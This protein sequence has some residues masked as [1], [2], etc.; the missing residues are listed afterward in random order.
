[1]IGA[2]S[3]Y[4]GLIPNINWVI[5]GGES[6]NK[7]GKYRYRECYIDWFYSIMHQCQEANVP[8]FIKQLGTY[9]AD[10]LKYKDRHG[11]DMDEWLD[12]LR[13]RQFPNVK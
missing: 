12:D 10:F 2:V 6:G 11:G 5:V 8:L 13:V 3:I 9:L 4:F 1:M 7:T